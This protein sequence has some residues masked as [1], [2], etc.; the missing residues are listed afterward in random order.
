M[1]P[2][3]VAVG[4]LDDGRHDARRLPVAVSRGRAGRDEDDRE[5][6]D[7]GSEQPPG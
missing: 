2:L 6:G 7:G 4:V 3:R 1:V 5:H